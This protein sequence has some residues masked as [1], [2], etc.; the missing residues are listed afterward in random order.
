[1]R[2][3]IIL[4]LIIILFSFCIYL[5]TLCP[6]IFV[7]D[8]GELIS[9]SYLMGVA[10]PPGYPLYCLLGKIITIMIPFASI[11]Y[12]VN[13]LSAVFSSLSAFI[14]F[15][16]ILRL[17]DLFEFS[18]AENLSEFLA[19]SIALTFA[20]SRTLWGQTIDAEVYTLHAL[21]VTFTVFLLI[22]VRSEDAV[23]QKY[24][25]YLFSFF[26]G[27]ALTNHHTLLLLSPAYALF[28]FYKK[29][30]NDIP[31]IS[32]IS[33]PRIYIKMAVLFILGLTLYLYLPI[34][35]FTYPI[36]NWGKPQ[37][38]A[39]FLDHL[40]RRQYGSLSE[41]SFSFF[42]LYK[43]A[44][45]YFNL[46]FREFSSYV[47]IAV[48]L[49][50]VELFRQKKLFLSSFL[51]LGWFS[52]CIT[53]I[54][55]ANFRATP[56]NISI[57]EVFFIP[58]YI[59]LSIIILFGLSLL[60]NIIR[61]FINNAFIKKGISFIVIFVWILP[62]TTNYSENNKNNFYLGYD[63]G[64][65]V[66]N[67]PES[68][69]YLFSAGDSS[70]FIAMYL[71]LVEGMRKDLTILDDTGTV[72]K[73]IY[74][75]EFI[76]SSQQAHD[77]TLNT[78]QINIVTKNPNPIYLILGN[79]V[80]NM[81]GLII[82]PQGLIFNVIRPFETDKKINFWRKY[83]LRSMFA[84]LK[85]PSYL[86]KDLR[87]Q[88]YFSLAEY[89]FEKGNTDLAIKTYNITAEIGKEVDAIKNSLAAT[90]TRKNLIE[91]AFNESKKA[92]EMYPFNPDVHNA[93]GASYL[94][95]REFDKAISEF[96]RAIELQPNFSEAYNNLGV[97][98]LRMGILD[99]SI[100]AYKKAIQIK[101]EDV[102]LYKN[103]GIAYIQDNKPKEAEECFRTAI[104]INP[105]YP[106]L[107]FQLANTFLRTGRL[108]EA[109]NEY[110]KAIEINNNYMEA[111][112]NLGVAYDNL[113][114]LDNAIRVYKTALEINPN[115]AEAHSNLGG[116]YYNK[117]MINEAIREW[118]I[119]LKLDPNQPKA[120]EFLNK[121]KH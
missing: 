29:D 70:T 98:Y 65:N 96:S 59:F 94:G 76:K 45:A 3:C 115:Y 117:G 64:I 52:G 22:K 24:F 53:Y 101:S 37:T 33:K 120:R 118:E 41:A 8:A 54:L 99:K 38:L 43:Q 116:S 91:L 25:L 36:V 84:D 73:N 21:F 90:Y 17:K 87:A 61:F 119:A 121:V 93:L 107:Y 18:L 31:V 103:L 100:E 44:A 105:G 20:F 47:F 57:V 62:L 42:L 32:V 69:S 79:N 40:L 88:H 85:L 14:L 55:I 77:K 15:F 26:F 71:Q 7:G 114:Q 34:R 108:R 11:A 9:A 92:V 16:I 60:I 58:S 50:I 82:K 66:L 81:S 89:Y 83:S 23:Q 74:G 5:I 35:S 68:N 72:F 106:E 78:I 67:T 111:Y 104:S 56:H 63:Y 95:R 49:G 97:T 4:P 28:V 6:S 86:E 13:I 48:F 102:E 46:A 19:F 39:Y 51:I 113:K 30:I 112:N 109:V 1:M 110:K 10:H 2:K 27:L 80:H 75:D 12:R